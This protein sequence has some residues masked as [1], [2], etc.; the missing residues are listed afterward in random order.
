MHSDWSST[1]PDNCSVWSVEHTSEWFS[2][3][4]TSQSRVADFSASLEKLARSRYPESSRLLPLSRVEK[5]NMSAHARDLNPL[6]YFHALFNVCYE[7]LVLHQ[8]NMFILV[9]FREV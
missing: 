6:T 5:L 8:D 1:S 3:D 4:D 7:I 9:L 2:P